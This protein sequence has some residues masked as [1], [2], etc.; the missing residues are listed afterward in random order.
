[1]IQGHDN[2]REQYQ[3]ERQ[4]AESIPALSNKRFQI[5]PLSGGMTNTNFLVDTGED[6]YVL[7]IAGSGSEILGISREVEA[8]CAARASSIGL[9]PDLEFSDPA[10]GISLTRFIEGETLTPET[11]KDPE[12]LKKIAVSL[13]RL[14]G[15]HS[16]SGEFSTF[17]TVRDYSNKAYLRNVTF[18]EEFN[19]AIRI[20]DDIEKALGSQSSTKVPCHNDLLAANFI[21]DS[22]KIWVIDWEYAGM[23]NPYFD[24][25]NF[26]VNQSLSDDE[27]KQFIELYGTEDSDAFE[28]V[29]LMQ[30]ASDLREASWGYL[31]SAVSEIDFDY[32]GY[33]K[34]H[35]DRFIKGSQQADFQNWIA[36]VK[37]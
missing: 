14:H 15:A 19:T 21:K 23:G 34:E 8:D 1:M 22:E 30:V 24:L 26:A 20:M 29:K 35:L 6:K 31:Q 2:G 5:S 7:R 32:I 37:G 17:D 3:N 16:F 4:I 9:A 10:K 12:N 28:R 33:G 27:I 11:M 36:K 18:P 13:K 25:A